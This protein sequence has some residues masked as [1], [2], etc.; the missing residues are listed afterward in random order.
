MI[1]WILA[2][3]ICIACTASAGA[4]MRVLAFSGST[5]E[6]S[7]NQQLVTEAANIARS[8]GAKVTVVNLRDFQIPFYDADLETNQGM[9]AKAKEL[10]RLMVESQVILIASPEYNGAPSAVLK[11]VIDWSSRG[12]NGGGSRD[13]FKGKRFAIMSA[14]PGGGGGAKGLVQLRAT[15]EHIGATVV[16]GQ[17]VVPDAFNAFDSNGH[18]KNSQQQSDLKA[19][20]KSALQV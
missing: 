14:S 18:L 12:E 7:T 1:K 15:L 2:L 8:L 20:V 10:R 4:E 3:G 19:L 11:N 9:P 17:V 16:P 6:G 13:A 5:R